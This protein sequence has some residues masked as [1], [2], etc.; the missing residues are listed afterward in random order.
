MLSQVA[1]LREV[2]LK[3]CDGVTAGGLSAVVA[4]M[5]LERLTVT[6][7]SGILPDQMRTIMRLPGPSACHQL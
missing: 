7:C 1:G 2:R 5:S 6:Q 4:R 3:V